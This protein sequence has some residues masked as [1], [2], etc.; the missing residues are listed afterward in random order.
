[1]M[2]WED[3]G[4]SQKTTGATKGSPNK[5]TDLNYKK[6]LIGFEMLALGAEVIS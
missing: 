1:M 4:F 3:K 5:T 2:S 6:R